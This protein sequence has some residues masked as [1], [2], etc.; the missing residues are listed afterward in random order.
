[1]RRPGGGADLVRVDHSALVGNPTDALLA[2][3]FADGFDIPATAPDAP[4]RGRRG[5]N[6]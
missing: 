6:P 5:R 4:V 3:Y 1:V 2:N